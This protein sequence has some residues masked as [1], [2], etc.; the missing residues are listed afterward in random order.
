MMRKRK[1]ARAI[2]CSLIIALALTACM[3]DNKAEI[4]K[5]EPDAKGKLKIAYPN[6]SDFN[7]RYGNAFKAKF[8]NIE[9][10][11]IPTGLEFKG[12][13][14]EEIEKQ[15]K[16]IKQPS[17]R[18]ILDEKQP[19]LM[20]V[21]PDEYSQLANDGRLY[22]LNAVIKR[23]GFDID[24]FQPSI[25]ESIKSLGNGKLY[26]LSATFKSRALYYNKNLFDKYGVPYP[27]DGMSWEDVLQLAARFPAKKDGADQLYG[28]SLYEDFATPFSLIDAI[29]T[30][31]GITYAQEESDLLTIDT[32]EWNKIFQSVINGYK[33][34]GIAMPE[35]EPSIDNGVKFVTDVSMGDGGSIVLDEQSAKFQDGKS[36]M[37]IDDST[38]L[39]A[40]I[41]AKQTGGKAAVESEIN[42]QKIIRHGDGS[43]PGEPFEWDIVTV[44]VDPSMPN[45][46]EGV[47]TNGMF[48]MNASSPNLSAGWEF[49]KLANS[50]QLAKTGA[51][52]A[53]GVTGSGLTTRL[54][55]KQDYDGKN[56]DAFYAYGPTMKSSSDAELL[57]PDSPRAVYNTTLSKLLTEHIRKVVDGSET[58][59]AALAAIQTQGQDALTKFRTDQKRQ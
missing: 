12:V 29:A 39:K 13:S 58:L 48:V 46:A 49:M 50:E 4:A 28:L 41:S 36:A 45:V 6:E 51:S 59:D 44:P 40:M 31:K 54:A 27:T 47:K 2:G 23:D 16:E 38:L 7:S 26:G 25:V 43:N 10:E 35:G 8:P 32:P 18:E 53:G 9:L 34:G 24:K 55:T 20:F 1:L 52:T 14:R 11:I 3:S 17:I 37:A 42:G 19:D 5:L 22:D 56:I 30:A 21:H 33:S 15:L 57:L